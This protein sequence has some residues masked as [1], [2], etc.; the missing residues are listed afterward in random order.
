[1]KNK[2]LKMLCLI[3]LFAS[4]CAAVSP[5]DIAN[6]QNTAVESKQIS[7]NGNKIIVKKKQTHKP[8]RTKV[9]NKVI[10]KIFKNIFIFKF[11]RYFMQSADSIDAIK[12]IKKISIF[13]SL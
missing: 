8:K 13:I 7:Q 10:I 6:L 4:F 11:A 9:I 3:S 2:I 12:Q 5:S 1:M